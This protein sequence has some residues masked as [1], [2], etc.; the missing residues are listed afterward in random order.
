MTF[1]VRRHW[2]LLGSLLLTSN[3]F[4]QLDTILERPNEF[5]ELDRTYKPEGFLL[6]TYDGE[7]YQTHLVVTRLRN[8]SIDLDA[9]YS[10]PYLATPQF[11]GFR[12]AREV[13]TSSV[14]FNDTTEEFGVDYPFYV[15]QVKEVVWAKSTARL[16]TQ[17][18]E[19]KLESYQNLVHASDYLANHDY[20][21]NLYNNE[22]EMIEWVSS[23][24]I[25]YYR[26]GHSYDGGAHGNYW[27]EQKLFKITPKNYNRKDPFGLKQNKELWAEIKHKAYLMA[28]TYSMDEEYYAVSPYDEFDSDGPEYD[29][30][31]LEFEEIEPEYP[32]DDY[33]D[34]TYKIRHNN[35]RL[36]YGVTFYAS[37]PY[38]VSHTYQLS[39]TV[40]V[41]PLPDVYNNSFTYNVCKEYDCDERHIQEIVLSPGRNIVIVREIDPSV[42]Y[43]GFISVYRTS[44]LKRI[45]RIDI[46][47]FDPIVMIE[48]CS[49]KYIESWEKIFDDHISYRFRDLI[50]FDEY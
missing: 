3:C 23:G 30:D 42:C 26:G 5:Y 37:A 31:T 13:P 11:D 44:D 19:K 33:E 6:G 15:N 41:G 7:Q 9:H 18:F 14:D 20:P 21:N 50:E 1:L 4:G 24:Y 47:D 40:W 38:I 2:L 27:A 28:L 8:D 25:Q 32:I 16:Y 10:I 12:Y 22:N 39:G 45:A 34:V 17:C 46:G 36:E 35:G 29:I 43:N 49:E 48:W